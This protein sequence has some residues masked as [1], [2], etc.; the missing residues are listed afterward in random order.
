MFCTL[1]PPAINIAIMPA[2]NTPSGK[3][4][5][6]DTANKDV[7][8]RF[9]A[10][11]AEEMT[12]TTN[13][14]MEPR[15]IVDFR[16]TVF[17]PAFELQLQEAQEPAQ[18]RPEFVMS[19][20]QKEKL[21]R[22]YDE[23][24]QTQR[25]VIETL[26]LGANDAMATAIVSRWALEIASKNTMRAE[27]V[28][29][30]L[31]LYCTY[32]AHVRLHCEPDGVFALYRNRKVMNMMNED[33][34]PVRFTISTDFNTNRRRDKNELLI[35]ASCL[36]IAAKMEESH[37]DTMIKPSQIISQMKKVG[38]PIGRHTEFDFVTVERDILAQLHW[39]LFRV[40]TPLFFVQILFAYF[41][42][43]VADQLE[44][45][46]L[47]AI[48]VSSKEYVLKTPARLAAFC[49]TAALHKNRGS[50]SVLA[51]TFEIAKVANMRIVKLSNH[52]E[53]ILELA[54]LADIR[55][56]GA[57]RDTSQDALDSA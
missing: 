40:Q 25:A 56:K 57:S 43:S 6:S 11:T 12:L 44:T 16:T 38:H 28:Y 55:D 23:I 20:H 52:A 3:R 35:A 42:V 22:V 39:N 2:C 27:T 53:C 7:E 29:T 33:Y 36:C 8:K 51:E 5:R 13:E 54:R 34:S 37:F 47:L 49:L 19:E 21:L 17:T 31:Y 48:C 41:D 30:G 46:N 45:N 24:Q 18:I 10:M 9:C 1:F 15:N 4:P 50:C 32:M 26:G 14:E